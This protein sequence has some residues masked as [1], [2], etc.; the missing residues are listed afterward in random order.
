MSTT[1]GKA[2]QEID[3][4][5]VIPIPKELADRSWEVVIESLSDLPSEI[6]LEDRSST[7]EVDEEAKNAYENDLALRFSLSSLSLLI[8]I[9]ILVAVVVALVVIVG[10]LG[11]KYRRARF[12]TT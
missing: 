1:I 4:A 5:V 12:Q 7:E 8:T 6:T 2:G 3:E 10:V 11:H 9:G